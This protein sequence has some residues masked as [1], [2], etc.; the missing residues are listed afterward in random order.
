VDTKSSAKATPFEPSSKRRR[1]YPSETVVKRGQRLVHGQKE[2]YEKLG[3]N[4][5]C[6]CGSGQ[7]F[8]TV[9]PQYRQV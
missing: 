2:L 5:P 7:R 4:D 1:G 3:N 8:Q 9:L 6:P